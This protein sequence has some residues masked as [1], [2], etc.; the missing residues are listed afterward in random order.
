MPYRLI[1]AGSRSISDYGTVAHAIER[2]KLNPDLIV[3]GG[4]EGVDMC[5]EQYG[6]ENGLPV[7]ILPAKWDEHGKSAGAIR[8]E[9]MAKYADALV[10]VWDGS[11]SGTRHMIEEANKKGL[12]VLVY[13]TDEDRYRAN[14]ALRQYHE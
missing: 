13:L 1:V 9:K 10:A 4:A 14:E 6:K 3:S 8:N 5:G 12:P 7:H 11:S 2:S